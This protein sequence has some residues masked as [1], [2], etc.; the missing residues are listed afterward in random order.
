[1]E[2]S[3]S[4]YFLLSKVVQAVTGDDLGTF[5][6]AA[7]FQPL[8]LDMVL[9]PTA[10]IEGKAVSYEQ[11]DGKWQVA[12][13]RWVP[14]IGPGSIQTTPSQLVTWASQ[15]WEPTVGATSINAERFEGAVDTGQGGRYGAGLFERDTGRDLGRVLTHD[16][17]WGGFRTVFSV[18]S[19]HRVAVA[20]SCTSPTAI[21]QI[22]HHRTFDR[23]LLAAWNGSN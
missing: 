7:L 6:A 3:N 10:A 18:A 19:E 20:V 1:M 23:D 14:T 17:A 2:Y 21:G 22:G 8:G 4:N 16:G 13:S 11:V 12:D 9:D 15:Y 5:L